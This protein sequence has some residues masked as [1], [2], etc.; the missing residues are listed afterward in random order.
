MRIEV[1]RL[2]SKQPVA[3]AVDHIRER[4]YLSFRHTIDT[5]GTTNENG[6]VIL[7]APVK[8]PFDTTISVRDNPDERWS[9]WHPLQAGDYSWTPGYPVGVAKPAALE[10]R[11]LKAPKQPSE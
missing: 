2:D 7:A 1:R 9:F 10:A 8:D 3:G 6:V 5:S 4:R 11:V